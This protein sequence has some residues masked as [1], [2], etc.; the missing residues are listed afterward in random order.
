MGA[1]RRT[2]EGALRRGV[3]A[4]ARGAVQAPRRPPP[5]EAEL[6]PEESGLPLGGLNGRA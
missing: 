1:L 3:A 4:A 6:A 2:K 5:L